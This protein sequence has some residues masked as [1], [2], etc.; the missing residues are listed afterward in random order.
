MMPGAQQVIRFP[1]KTSESVVYQLS[2]TEFQGWNVVS[3]QRL[4]GEGAGLWLTCFSKRVE[5]THRGDLRILLPK[6]LD[7][8][9]WPLRRLLRPHCLYPGAKR[10]STVNPPRSVV[11]EDE[12]QILNFFAPKWRCLSERRGCNGEKGMNGSFCFSGATE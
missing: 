6:T 3:V 8:Q 11:V 7:K 10:A 12:A 2:G 5:W 4:L 9:E 1:R